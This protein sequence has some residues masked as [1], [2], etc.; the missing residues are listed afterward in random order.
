[1]SQRAEQLSAIILKDF[2][3]FLLKEVELP[4]DCLVTIT[5]AEVDDDLATVV[6]YLSVLPINRRGDIIKILN[7]QTGRFGRFLASRVKMRLV[8]KISFSYDETSLK[9][10]SV[11]RELEKIAEEEKARNN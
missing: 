11:E 2:N 5:N 8:P 6:I 1:M 9:Y 3:D 7:K 10:R 4:R